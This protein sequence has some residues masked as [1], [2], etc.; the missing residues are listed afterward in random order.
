MLLVLMFFLSSA[1]RHSILNWTRG[2]SEC[3]LGGAHPMKSSYHG[4]TSSSSE[5]KSSR[6]AALRNSASARASNRWA[7]TST[8]PHRHANNVINGN[9]MRGLGPIAPLHLNSSLINTL[10][11]SLQSNSSCPSCCYCGE[12]LGAP[13]AIRAASPGGSS[14]DMAMMMHDS[15][16]CSS[17]SSCSSSCSSSAAATAASHNQMYA[18]NLCECTH[19]LS[20]PHL[21]Q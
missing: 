9:S 3:K 15:P 21:V 1:S 17:S 14:C 7:S 13:N 10:S 5:L 4:V 18:A 11:N 2:D 16:S 20:P 12:H 8:S 19:L 6:S